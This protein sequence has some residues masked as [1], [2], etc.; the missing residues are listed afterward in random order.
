[1]S[2]KLITIA[3][4]NG[5]FIPAE[6]AK[7]KDEKDLAVEPHTPVKVPSAYG[8]SLVADRLAYLWD[9]AAE[10][11]AAKRT[12]NIGGTAPDLEQVRKEAGA[13]VA[14]AEEVAEKIVSDA[15]LTAGLIAA[16]AE[17]AAAQTDDAKAVA[18]KKIDD[19]TQALKPTE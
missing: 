11:A 13:I 7:T 1:M 19:A 2:E 10:K 17:L 18:Q 5:G 15:H 14:K 16:K 3:F 4:T 12:S 8:A 6:I 9:A